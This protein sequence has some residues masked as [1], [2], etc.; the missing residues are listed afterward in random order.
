MSPGTQGAAALPGSGCPPGRPVGLL[1]KLIAAV[2]PEF[3]TDV[4]VFDP[5]DPVFGGPAC[6]A[7][8]QRP[9]RR[10]GLCPGHYERWRAAGKPDLA[11]FAAA[12]PPDMAACRQL[13]ACEIAGCLYGQTAR[14][15]C[16]R[17]RRQWQ[18]AGCPELVSWRASAPPPPS[19]R[20]GCLPD[21]PLRP[22]GVPVVAVLPQ[23]SRAVDQARAARRGPVR[24]FLPGRW[25]W[26][27]AHRP[28][29]TARDAAA[30][31]AV[32][33]SGPPG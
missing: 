6:A 10:R 21:G 25:A 33:A 16:E 31:G 23:P 30:G 24:H 26:R 27:R 1:E 12:T 5:R 17:H 20:P 9:A 32:R 7:G 2:R 13:P 3:R 29:A 18:R 22:V 11:E 8:C 15:I 4:L 28:A 14:G 19:P